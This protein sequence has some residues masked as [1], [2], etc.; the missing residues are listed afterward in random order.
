[1]A[2]ELP[3]LLL[4]LMLGPPC[5]FAVVPRSLCRCLRNTPTA[6]PP[7]TVN[8]SVLWEAPPRSAY[9]AVPTAPADKSMKSWHYTCG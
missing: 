4:M 1:M 5:E 3:L 2:A 6:C 9:G 7:S 8:T